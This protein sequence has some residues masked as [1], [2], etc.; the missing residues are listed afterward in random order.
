[1]RGRIIEKPVFPVKEPT[2]GDHETRSTIHFL[3]G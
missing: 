3:T 2:P 1:M